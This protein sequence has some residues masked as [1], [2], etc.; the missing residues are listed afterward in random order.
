MEIKIRARKWGN[1]IG[2]VIPRD[3]ADA[4]KIKENEDVIIEIKRR[5]LAAEFFGKFPRKSGKTAQKLKDEAR[6]GWN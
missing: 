3:I 6:K 4:K 1:S 2:F 5:P